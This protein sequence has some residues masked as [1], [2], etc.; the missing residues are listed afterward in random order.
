VHARLALKYIR[1]GGIEA[2]PLWHRTS[3][4]ASRFGGLR[5]DG[6]GAQVIIFDA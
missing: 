1:W 4:R 5:F 2:F 6:E 3:D